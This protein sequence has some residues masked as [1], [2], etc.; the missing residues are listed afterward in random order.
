MKRLDVVLAALLVVGCAG[1][2]GLTGPTGPQGPQGST[3]PQGPAGAQGLPGPAGTNGTN[4][5]NGVANKYVATI[6]PTTSGG[7]YAILPAAVGTNPNAP[8]SMACY[9]Q[10]P[11]TLSWW[12]VSDGY[13]DGSEWCT[14][15][16]T[17]GAWRAT[18][19]NVTA[20]WPVAFVVI[21]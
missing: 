13:A 21:Y 19:F 1:R 6:T 15:S 17:L 20:G 18:M 3:G 12:Q 11:M 7:V 14:L 8:P 4:G 16:F 10:N 2:D 9:T 5:T